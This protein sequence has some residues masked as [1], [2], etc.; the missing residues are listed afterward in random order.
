[1]QTLGPCGVS[2][3]WGFSSQRFTGISGTSGHC[4]T[5]LLRSVSLG[6]HGALYELPINRGLK[7]TIVIKAQIR[8]LGAADVQD[9]REIRLSALKKAPE[10]FGSVYEHEE[11]KPMEA[12][13]ER[14]RDAVA[15][16]AYIDGEIIGLS[17]FKQEDGPKDAHKAHLSGV[18]VE[19]EQR[20]RGVAGMLL[21]AV[22]D[23]GR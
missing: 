8:R 4:S 15:F 19:P 21:R 20:G 9:F 18:F 6:T 7:L 2:S 5:H 22:I 13:A 23:Y 3:G 11:K 1:M 12:F 14:L 10:M 17:V 16:G